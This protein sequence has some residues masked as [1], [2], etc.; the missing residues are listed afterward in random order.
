MFCKPQSSWKKVTVMLKQIFHLGGALGRAVSSSS[1]TI[2]TAT[3]PVCNR[4]ATFTRTMSSTPQ[5]SQS[6]DDLVKQIDVSLTP[7]QQVYVD[8]IK[9][10]IR[11]G[12]KSPRCKMYWFYCCY[13]YVTYFES[14]HIVFY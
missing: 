1:R 11:G 6:I 14:H 2:P 8:K 9:K 7:E 13:L 4:V 5:D 12:A 10:Q 3:G